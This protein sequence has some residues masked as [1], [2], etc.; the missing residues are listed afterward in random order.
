MS[1]RQARKFMQ[2]ADQFR[3]KHAE[4]PAATDVLAILSG[5]VPEKA[6]KEITRRLRAGEKIGVRSARKIVNKHLA[7]SQRAMCGAQFVKL[8]SGQHP[9]KASSTELP[10]SDAIAC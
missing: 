10:S 4:L 9:R 5:N 3:M 8:K 7:T 1:E 6:R 2:I